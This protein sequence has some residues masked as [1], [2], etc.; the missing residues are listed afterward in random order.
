MPVPHLLFS[1]LDVG[2]PPIAAAGGPKWSSTYG[3]LTRL[4]HGK[5]L[6]ITAESPP[7]I[8]S[9]S[10]VVAVGAGSNHRTLATFLWRDAT[11][12]HGTG[13]FVSSD[14]VDHDLWHACKL[15]ETAC[16]PRLLRLGVL[17][18]YDDEPSNI[19]ARI[20]ALG[21]KAETNDRFADALRA[22]SRRRPPTRLL[23]LPDLDELE[24]LA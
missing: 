5:G 23:D 24:T 14:V 9:G 20:M 18:P 7:T 12:E 1:S 11:L 17:L 4:A 2:E 10:S 15:I 22:R 19:R 16:P 21:A 8:L 13:I 3:A 6:N